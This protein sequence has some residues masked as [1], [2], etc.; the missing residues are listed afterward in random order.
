MTKAAFAAPLLAALLF[1]ATF[2][3]ADHNNRYDYGSYDSYYGSY[4]GY[5]N[6]GYRND[7]HRKPTCS[8]STYRTSGANPYDG[9]VT[10]TW[11]SSNATHAYV[12]G[13]GT[14]ATAG[15]QT[16]YD[17]SY[18]SYTLTVSGPGGSTTCS[19]SSPF[20]D[21]GSKHN[22]YSYNYGYVSNPAFNYS[23][24]S[25]P[26]AAGTVY[27][28]NYVTL[29]QVP[30]TGFDFGTFGNSLYWL[31]MILLAAAGAY[32]IVYSHSGTMPR[33]FAQ[34][35]AIAARNQIRLVKTIVR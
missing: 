18:S 13:L 3:Y 33:A 11:W 5:D 22:R 15:T 35:V 9:R 6:Y 10:L 8:I 12:T 21:A 29:S 2:A 28:T 1:G 31:A 14:V 23:L 32:L 24:Y 34:E 4:G 26:Y 7:Y 25:Y 30:Y 16:V 17:S 19:A 20:Y 27:P